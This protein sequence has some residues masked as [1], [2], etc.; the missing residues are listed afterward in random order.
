MLHPDIPESWHD[1]MPIMPFTPE[2]R[3]YA[4][5]HLIGDFLNVPVTILDEVLQM[6]LR[7]YTILIN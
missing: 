6:L 2:R 1:L 4:M 3:I 5:L 7:V